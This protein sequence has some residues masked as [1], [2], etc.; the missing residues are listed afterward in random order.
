MLSRGKKNP[1]AV[2]N[3]NLALEKELN[4]NNNNNKKN[5]TTTVHPSLIFN[6]IFFFSFSLLLKQRKKERVA[7][8]LP[9]AR[10]L[11]LSLSLLKSPSLRKLSQ[12]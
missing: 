11:S 8:T 9:S 10:S 12:P 6:S 5:P 2:R 1:R 4:S 3:S 7:T